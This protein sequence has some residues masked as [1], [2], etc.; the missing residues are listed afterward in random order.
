MPKLEVRDRLQTSELA[1]QLPSQDR[2]PAKVELVVAAALVPE[3]VR[4]NFCLYR[5]GGGL[6]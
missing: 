2:S 6:R 4:Y 1:Q 5:N 3:E